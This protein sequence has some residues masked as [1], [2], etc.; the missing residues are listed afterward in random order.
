MRTVSLDEDKVV[1]IALRASITNNA[2]KG[3]DITSEY[4]LL[5]FYHT[6]ETKTERC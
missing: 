2:K 6:T 3:T 4:T 5:L 1:I